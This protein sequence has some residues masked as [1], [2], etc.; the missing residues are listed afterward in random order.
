MGVCLSNDKNEQTTFFSNVNVNKE[1][2]NLTQCNHSTLISYSRICTTCSSLRNNQ[3][4]FKA[5]R[6]IFTKL[7][8]KK[9]KQK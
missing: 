7:Q 3:N 8:T 5:S 6:P 9:T 2:T 1:I 4:L